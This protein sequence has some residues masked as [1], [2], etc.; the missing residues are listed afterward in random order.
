MLDEIIKQLTKIKKK[1]GAIPVLYVFSEA[2]E[3]SIAVLNDVYLAYSDIEFFG[4]SIV[5][6]SN[7]NYENFI[8]EKEYDAEKHPNFKPVVII[9]EKL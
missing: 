3:M 1:H 2:T 4:S 6:S 7:V 5:Y 9:T 8:N